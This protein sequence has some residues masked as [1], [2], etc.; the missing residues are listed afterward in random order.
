MAADPVTDLRD[1]RVLIPATRRAIDGPQATGSA[2]PSTTL[3]DEMVLSVI[4]DALGEIILLTAGQFGYTLEVTAR[5]DAYL[6]PIAWQTD[7][8][9]STEA[10]AVITAQAAINYHFR[11]LS[12]LKSS[13]TI[14]DKDGE[15]SYSMSA[16]LLRDWLKELANMRD[17]A[18]NALARMNAPMDTYV[19]TVSARDAWV[20]RIVEPWVE[21]IGGLGGATMGDADYRFGTMG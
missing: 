3:T 7:K 5:D 20:G 9:R 17:A 16:N 4:A 11:R 13:E 1:L 6:A 8:P 15:W 21:G 19:S 12:E 10:D 2:A 18:L 14:T